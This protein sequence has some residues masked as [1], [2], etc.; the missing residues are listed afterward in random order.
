LYQSIKKRLKLFSKILLE[1]LVVKK[2]ED[3]YLHPLSDQRVVD[4]EAKFIVYWEIQ[5]FL[6]LEINLK[7]V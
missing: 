1:K 4:L 7:K 3:V 6:G 2:K 5:A